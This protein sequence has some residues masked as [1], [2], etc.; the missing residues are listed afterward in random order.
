[1]ADITTQQMIQREDPRVEDYR[2]RLLREAENLALNVQPERDAS[3]KIITEPV[4]DAQ[5]KPVIDSLTGQAQTRPK[6]VPT[7]TLA[8]QLPKYEVAG[9]QQAQLD[10]MRRA[11][12]TGIGAFDPYLASAR[13]SL[14]GGVGLTGEAANVLRGADTRGQFTDAQRAIQQAGGAAAGITSGLGALTTGQQLALQSAQANLAPA[15]QAIGQG[16]QGLSQAQQMAAA[17]GQQAGFGQGVQTALTAAE[18]ARLAAAQPGFAAA[19]QTIQ[20]GLGQ[21]GGAAQAYNP[22]DAQA[23]MNPYQQQVIDEAMRQISRQGEIAQ[24]GLS[25]QAV[26]SGAFGGTREGVQRAELQRGLMEQKA[27]TI[28]NLLNQ[29][30]SQ[31]QAN[32]MATFEQQQQRQ[33]AGAQ[34]IGQLGMQ[35]ASIAAQQAG[36]GQQAAQQL[37]Q[38]GQLQTQAAGQQ[39]QLQQGA[40]GLYGNL[41]GQQIG[42]GQGLGQLGIQQAGLGQQA[43]GQM[44]QA[45]QGI[46]NIYGQQAGQMQNLGLGIGQLANQQFNIGQQQAMGLGQLGAQMGQLGVQ[47]GALGQTGQAMYQGD[48]NFLYN[49][50]QAQQAQQQQQMDA[51][52]AN[53]LQQVYAPY[54]QAAFLSDIYR[55]APSSQMQTAAASQPSASPFQ[56][57]AGTALGVTA[58]AAGAKKAGLFGP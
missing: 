12:A 43:A 49:I 44:M 51:A 56:Q 5:G 16:M 35:Q 9:F 11:E 2:L 14:A 26:R 3:G 52:R 21:L 27:N 48:V 22:A 18:E 47:Q 15:T 41:A 54:Q 13:Q 55:G 10:A 23:F 8:Q 28:A 6:L 50:G 58:A 53:Q 37:A 29:G 32:A 40:A 39:G 36:L 19:Q 17:S 4:L 30:Y 7:Q 24:Q 42:A 46:A 45:G 38:A 20:Q 31:A 57:V 25:A 34:G 33:M 1:M